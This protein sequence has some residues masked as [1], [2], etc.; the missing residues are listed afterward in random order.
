MLGR[1]SMGVDECIDT[2]KYLMKTIFEKPSYPIHLNGNIKG[3]FD[4]Q[5]LEQLVKKVVAARSPSKSKDEPF[6]LESNFANPK[7]YVHRPNLSGTNTEICAIA[8]YAQWHMKRRESLASEV[9]IP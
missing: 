8:S 6:M 2:Y 1:L 9:M 7:V 3:R 4:S 5:K